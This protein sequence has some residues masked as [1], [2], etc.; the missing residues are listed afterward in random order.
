LNRKSEY[1]V[2]LG[3]YLLNLVTVVSVIAFVKP[4]PDASILLSMYLLLL[5][6]FFSYATAH[7]KK[8]K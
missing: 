7:R 6:G 1:W 5:T 2:F 3:F 4:H 8:K